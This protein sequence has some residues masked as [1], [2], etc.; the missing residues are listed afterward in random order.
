M[1]HFQCFQA[2]QLSWIMDG[3]QQLCHTQNIQLPPRPELHNFHTD[4][5]SNTTGTEPI[6]DDEEDVDITSV[7]P[8]DDEP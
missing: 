4:E 5:D 1:Q 8:A 2:A 7:D 6:L 3:L